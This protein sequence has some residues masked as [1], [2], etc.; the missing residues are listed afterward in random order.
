MTRVGVV[1]ND[2]NSAHHH[3]RG[4]EP[5]LG[6]DAREKPLALDA[7]CLRRQDLQSLIC[8]GR[9]NELQEGTGFFTTVHVI[10]H[11]PRLVCSQHIPV[12]PKCSLRN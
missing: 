6:H 12:S 2:A 11:A 5:A 8:P 9:R 4:A 3:S 10:V 7:E 1:I